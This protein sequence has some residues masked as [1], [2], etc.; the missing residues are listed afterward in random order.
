MDRIRYGYFYNTKLL[1]HIEGT[2]HPRV[3]NVNF[4]NA[5]LKLLVKYETMGP[6]FE[7]VKPLTELLDALNIGDYEVLNKIW[8]GE[9]T[10]LRKFWFLILQSNGLH[11]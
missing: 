4:I 1:K 9:C 6:D 11:F 10:N 8:K 5:T 3:N 7:V 2:T